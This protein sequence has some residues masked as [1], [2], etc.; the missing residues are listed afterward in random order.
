M[1]IEQCVL[2]RIDESRE[3][4]AGLALRLGNTYSPWGSERILAARLGCA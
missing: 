4:L 3:D 2:D 1:T